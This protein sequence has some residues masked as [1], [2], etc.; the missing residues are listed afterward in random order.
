MFESQSKSR[1]RKYRLV[2][3]TV[4]VLLIAFCTTIEVIHTH[5]LAGTPRPDCVLCLVAH[6][7]VTTSPHFVLAIS[8]E[9]ISTVQVFQEDS[10]RELFVFSYFC[11]PPPAELASD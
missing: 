4:C 10:P 9:H 8:L 2:L 3:A 5:D 11:R 7:G 1:L 6:E